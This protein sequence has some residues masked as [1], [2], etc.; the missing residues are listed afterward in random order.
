MYNTSQSTKMH[1]EMPLDVLEGGL[2]ISDV[3]EECASSYL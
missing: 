3:E 2:P 1:H